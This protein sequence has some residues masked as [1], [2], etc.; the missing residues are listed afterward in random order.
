M[1]TGHPFQQGLE[2][3]CEAQMEEIMKDHPEMASK[4]IPGFHPGCRRLSPGDGYLEALQQENAKICWSPIECIT[5]NGIR[6]TDGEEEFDLI[7]C[8]TGFDTTFIPP[9]KLV[10]LK[11]ATLKER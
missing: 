8:A 2:A 3:M 10:G 6:T 7:V 4:M 1:Y 11:G 5:K 9:W